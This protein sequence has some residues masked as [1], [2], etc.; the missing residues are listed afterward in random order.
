MGYFQVF[1]RTISRLPAQAVLKTLDAE[2]EAIRVELEN[3]RNHATPDEL[4]VLCFR[5]Y[6]RLV[7]RKAVVPCS[8]ILP[9]D[10]LEF[11]KE[12]IVRLIQEGELP[13]SAMEEF[14]FAFLL[15]D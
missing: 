6:V 8:K 1:S 9:P 14:D 4:S 7:K 15:K 13:A 10:H 12:T 2:C 11:F 3:G 5:E